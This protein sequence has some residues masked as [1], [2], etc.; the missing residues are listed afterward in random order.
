MPLKITREGPVVRVAL[1]RPEV[2]NAF[3]A[4][5][6]RELREAFESLGADDS[7]RAVALSGEG[8]VFCAGAD[9]EWMRA[10]LDLAPE[11][12][13]EDAR[14]MAAMFRAVDE[15]PKIVVGLVHGAAMG[16][17][18]GLVACCDV[19]IAEEDAK[20]AFS[21]VKLGIVS[22]VISS[23]VLPKIGVSQA[24]FLL[25]TGSTFDAAV[26]REIGLV[27]AVV[28]AGGREPSFGEVRDLL[29]RPGPRAVAEAKAL[30]RAVS[31][32]GRDEAIDRCVETIARVRT[33][34]EGQEGLRAFLE[35]R[36]PGWVSGAP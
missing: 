34:P 4:D 16:G 31:R 30:L 1:D 7:V 24:R 32:M 22:A 25:L 19:V 9:A 33:S 27:H 11:E 8:K 36:P 26:A 2:R 23:F 18:A 6:I 15:C 5:L 20:F 10:S 21:E 35:K 13:R 3:D 12:N 29:L 17:G 28:P 14:R